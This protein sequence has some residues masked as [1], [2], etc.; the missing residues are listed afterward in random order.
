MYALKTYWWDKVTEDDV[1]NEINIFENPDRHDNQ[2]RYFGVVNNPVKRCFRLEFCLD[3]NLNYLL[4]RRGKLAEEEVWY[5]GTGIEA[6]LAHLH[7]KALIH[8]DVKPENIFFSPTM[9][10]QNRG[11]WTRGKG[12][13]Q[14]QEPMDRTGR[15]EKKVYT[16]GLDGKMNKNGMSVTA[17]ALMHRLLDFK[18]S[19]RP[20]LRRMHREKSFTTGCCPSELHQSIF[21]EKPDF[22]TIK[23]KFRTSHARRPQGQS[24]TRHHLSLKNK[25]WGK[26]RHPVHIM[27][28]DGY[29]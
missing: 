27:T 20:Q 13:V 10:G 22:K 7:K 12:L 19:V 8:C 4:K 11:P 29:S 16:K 21:D 25:Y 1:D 9:D 26:D 28:S 5:I 18:P 24:Q 23:R 15:R 2:V 3:R 14:A 6:G 17:N